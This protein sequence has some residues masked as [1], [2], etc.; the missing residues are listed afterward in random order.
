MAGHGIPRHIIEKAPSPCYIVDKGA[1]RRNLE[2]LAG[3]QERTGCTI[4]LALKG[5]AMF[6]V[7]PEVKKHLP[8]ISASSLNE[9]R[10]GHEEFGG[11]LHVVCPAYR[12]DE[13]PTLL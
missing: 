1:L 6:S 8:G 3:V 9:A 5:F 12:D 7:F 2:L 4:L 10:L 13:F 11:L